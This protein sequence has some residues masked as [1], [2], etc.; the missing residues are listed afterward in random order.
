MAGRSEASSQRV[1]SSQQLTT[2]G[3]PAGP[4]PAAASSAAPIVS[5][6]RTGNSAGLLAAP[7]RAVAG[8]AQVIAA[9]QT[10]R[11]KA[12]SFGRIRTS[13]WE[14]MTEVGTDDGSQRLA[15]LV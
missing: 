13:H 14:A 2:P 9:C 11:S 4:N 10:V 1:A 15:V 6:A 8:L 5:S 3:W 12:E 7:V